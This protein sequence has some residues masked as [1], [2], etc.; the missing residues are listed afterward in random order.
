MET[1]GKLHQADGLAVALGAR[2]AEIVSQARLG[3]V[4]LLV[5]DD[6]DGLA[7]EPAE[8][9][10]DGLVLAEAAVAGERREVRDQPLHVIGEMRPL[11]MAR[12]QR[13]L[14][15][16]ESGVEVGQRFLGFGLEASQLLADG[17]RA[18]A[19]SHRTQFL[20]LGLEFGNGFFEVEV[21]AH[22]HGHRVPCTTGRECRTRGGRM[23]V[24][25]G[26]RA[27]CDLA[28][29]AR[30]ASGAETGH[31]GAR[32]QGKAGRGA[33]ARQGVALFG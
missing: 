28:A 1:V 10:D 21:G 29:R 8:A 22:T 25:P 15:R 9:A 12:D 26:F 19:A 11:R 18:F 17:D 23:L 20:D 6:T 5:A 24:D 31:N 7:P 4:A 33:Y 14:P 32:S 30:P 2:H 27:G 16:G 13:L 3:I